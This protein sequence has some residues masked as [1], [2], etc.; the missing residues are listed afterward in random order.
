MKFKHSRRYDHSKIKCSG[1]YRKARSGILQLA[2][3]RHKHTP[4]NSLYVGDRPEDE[5]A[6]QRAY[7]PFQW[8]WDWIEQ[9]QEA[10]VP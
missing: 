4:H 10:L 7:V 3:V 5:E 6:A 1:Q 2:M 9:H 8:A